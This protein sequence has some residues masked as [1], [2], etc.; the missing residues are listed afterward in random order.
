MV[1]RALASWFLGLLCVTA[2]GHARAG[3]PSP[4]DTAPAVATDPAFERGAFD[5]Q[6]AEGGMVSVQHTSAIRPNFDYQL[7]AIRLGYMVDTP[8]GSNFLRGNNEFLLEAI[9]GPVT[10]GPGSALGGLS[11]M[12]RRNFLSPG[13]RLVPYF[14]LSAGGIYSDAYHDKVQQALGSMFEFNLQ[15]GLGT[16]F[17]LSPRWSVDAEFSYRHFSN[18][19]ITQRNLGTNGIGGLIGV[20]RA[21]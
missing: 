2:A 4:K 21:F 7:T 16:R 5:L 9:S 19:H 11:I 14:H 8:H 1:A 20:S 6:F 10:H 18:A 13:A 12:Y 3:E 17:R 15:A